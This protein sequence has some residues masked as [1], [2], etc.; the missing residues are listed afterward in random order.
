MSVLSQLASALGRR[1]EVPNQQLACALA[2]KK[3]VAAIRDIVSNLTSK[4]KDIAGDCIKVMDELGRI[5]PG[6]VSP[7]LNELVALLTDRNNRLQW[8]AMAAL[9]NITEKVP[10]AIYANLALIVSAADKG[11]VITK[12]RCMNILVKLC[13]IK[14]YSKDAF[15]LLFEQLLKAPPNQLPMYAENA[16]AV[17]DASYKKQFVGILA[18][19]LADIEKET[20][21]QRVEKVIRK[22]K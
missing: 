19:R 2:K 4:N 5:D 21:R 7:H 11:S 14:A 15:N 8:G 17:I 6:L 9:D 1:D 20:K 13:R 10:K 22:F 18:S 16:S 3:D 12:D